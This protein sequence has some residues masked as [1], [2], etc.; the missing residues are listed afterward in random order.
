MSEICL[1]IFEGSH[2][3]RRA[4][5][6]PM[7]LSTMTQMGR[8]HATQCITLGHADTLRIAPQRQWDSRDLVG[9]TLDS[10]AKVRAIDTVLG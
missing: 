3:S 1:G 7:C 2:G 9:S 5:L 4:A 10:R 8:E 6:E